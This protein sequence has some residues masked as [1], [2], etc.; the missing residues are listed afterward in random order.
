[1]KFNP[2]LTSKALF[3]IVGGAVLINPVYA[4]EQASEELEEVV[5]TGLRSSLKQ[6]MEIKRDSIG[7]VDAITAED[8]GKF[9]DTNLAESLQRIP[10]VAIDR[11][12][13]EGSQV[14]VRG[15][16]PGYNLVTL[17]GR[18]V[19][20]AEVNIYGAQSAFSGPQGRSFDFSNIAAE[21]VSGLEVYKTGQALLPSGGIG[22][23]INVKTRRPFD[24]PGL[25]GS[26][27]VKALNDTSNETGDD[28]T[29]EVSGLFSWTN[30][31]ETLGLGVFGEYSK[32]DSGAA[33]GQTNGWNVRTAQD[34]MSNGAVVKQT[35]PAGNFVNM[36]PNGALY[37]IPD[38]SRYDVSDLTSERTNAQAVFQFRPVD[39]LTMTLDATYFQ[40]KTTEM[41][42]EQTN[43]FNTPFDHL[44][45]ETDDEGK[46]YHAVY[47][48]ENDNG[49]KDM[50]F[51]QTN[52]AQKDDYNSIGFNVEWALTDSGTLK[53][54]AHSDTARSLPNNP[55]G[56]TATFVAVGAPVILTHELSWDNSDHFP[57]QTY[58]MNDSVKANGNGTL[59]VGD[60]A[61]QQ[62]RSTTFRQEMDVDE[63]DLRYSVKAEKS[64]VD[65]GANL[66]KTKTNVLQAQTSQD[67][68]S[69][70]I[71]NPGDIEQLVPG[72]FEAFCM[73]CR[74]DD[75]PVGQA[76]IAFRADAT[77]IFGPLTTSTLYGSQ[78]VSS[79]VNRNEVKEDIMALY[80]QFGLKSE[81]LGRDV[82]I[83]GGLRY[84]VTEVDATAAQP[85]PE[86]IR[87]LADNDFVIDFAA[88]STGVTGA[89]RYN[90]FLPNIDI[91][92]DVTDKVVARM[93]YSET[94]GRVPYGSLF[95]ATTAQA[96]NNPTAFGGL[97]SGSA[98][99]PSLL[100]LESKNF[101]VSVEWYYGDDSYVSVG[102]F[103]KTVK[104][105]LG[106]SV[107]SRPLFGLLDPSSGAAGTRSGDALD[108]IADH[109][110]TDQS[111]ANL[112]TLV[113]LMDVNGGDRAAAE[114]AW[115]AALGTDGADPNTLPQSYIDLILGANDVVGVAG[116]DPE[117]QFRVN[118]PVNSDEG[119]INGW[120]FAWQ[121]FF[122][123]S[124]FGAA[125]SYTIV[126]GDVNADPNQDPNANQFAL[127]GLS[128]TANMTLMYEKYG[129]SARLAYNWRDDFLNGTNQGN[130]GSGQFTEAYGQFDMSISYDINDHIQV[131]L[132]GINLTGE[133]HREYRRYEGM[134]IW[135]YE[136]APRYGLSARYRF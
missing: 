18:T 16:G 112:F 129:I 13:G 89:G 117:M 95:A 42:M 54:D 58:T 63:F 109:P 73:S 10:G 134:T 102:F 92:M 29:P 107:V 130:N 70:G 22:A 106:N 43:W 24:T 104:N 5:V 40:N 21:A 128:D 36:P 84:E 50:G 116:E 9:P 121:H 72:A 7:V 64:T 57:V 38:D 114:A 51:E 75:F 120:E 48:Q 127:V 65:F 15:F 23:T 52:K 133:D 62:A 83:T 3:T 66:R 33:M 86:R 14:T 41:R 101:D 11:Q 125:A 69:W 53:L 90:H 76:N 99:D 12:N 93:S 110:G 135:A 60:L 20:T 122:G 77:D 79:S 88:G 39:S 17:N 46:F 30:D 131:Q 81:L 132:E 27:G 19:A 31:G 97:T 136:L 100:P 68:G 85:V 34:L 119:N 32:R 61:T 87:W 108:I 44:T 4:Q 103:D 28:F 115:A 123:G 6:S 113:A 82:S 55:L 98:Q 47:L 25:Q 2:K 111:P 94:I 71:A 124:G 26:I 67:L 118:Q 105:F 96:P 126:K 80:A 1:M 91:K 37:S 35:A 78:A 49:A 74:F 8:I 56:H 45:F 59:D